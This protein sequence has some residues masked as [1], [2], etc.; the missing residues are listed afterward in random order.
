MLFHLT[1]FVFKLMEVSNRIVIELL[2]L[3]ESLN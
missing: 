3:Q 2:Q 1:I